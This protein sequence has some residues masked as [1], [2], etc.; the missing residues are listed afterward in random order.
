MNLNKEELLQKKTVGELLDLCIKL[1]SDNE[2]LRKKIA[3]LQKEKV[4]DAVKETNKALRKENAELRKTLEKI[5][6]AFGV[7]SV[8]EEAKK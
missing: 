8:E 5:K 1:N 3:S 4:S 7:N 6:S 2:E